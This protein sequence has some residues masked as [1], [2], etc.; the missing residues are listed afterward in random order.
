MA[1]V[2]LTHPD[3]YEPITVSE[4]R[5]RNLVRQGWVRE[6]EARSR[7]NHPTAK[8]STPPDDAPAPSPIDEAPGPSAPSPTED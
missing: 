2:T 5:A 4:L 1:D 8:T 7:A 3:G 6:D